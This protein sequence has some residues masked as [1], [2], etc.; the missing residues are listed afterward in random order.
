VVD[1]ERMRA[2]LD[3]AAALGVQPAA[4]VPDHL[5]LDGPEEDETVAVVIGAVALV[6]G[7][8]LALSCDAG[9]LPL[10][11]GERPYR[12]VEAPGEA[13]RLACAAA[14]HPP[15]DLQ[16]GVF[17]RGGMGQD[18]AWK[19]P[20]ILAGLLAASLVAVPV[21][22]TLRYELATSAAVSRIDALAGPPAPGLPA[23]GPARLA[24]RVNRLRA[25][26][27]FPST[28]AALFAAIQGVDGMELQSLLYREDG[29]L[30]ATVAHANYSDV[31]VLKTTLARSNLLVEE[32]SAVT[33]QGGVKSDITVRARP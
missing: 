10:V 11:M 27:A 14:A 2:W 5:M 33:D 19:G 31:E 18:R 22:Q 20:L 21:V 26:E 17:A 32:K 23:E 9:L 1:R 6:R 8:R 13:E 29:T 24:V 4:V 15:V 28:A 16:Q 30:N 25:A 7:P 12:L 3:A